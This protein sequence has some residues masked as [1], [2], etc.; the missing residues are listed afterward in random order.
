VEIPGTLFK[1]VPPDRVGVLSTRLLRFTPP[2][3]FNDP[4]D[5]SPAVG[6]MAEE[7]D[8]R[9]MIAEGLDECVESAYGAMLPEFRSRVSLGEF[10][11]TA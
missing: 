5:S 9:R 3:E 4:F 11:A 1:Y 6:K 10:R 2:A 8:T 7:E